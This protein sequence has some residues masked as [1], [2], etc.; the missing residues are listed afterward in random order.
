MK[1]LITQNRRI[2]MYIGCF[3]VFALM[4][5]SYGQVTFKHNFEIAVEFENYPNSSAWGDIDNDGD[6]DAYMSVGS[7]VG[8]DIMFNDLANSG[9][10]VKADTLLGHVVDTAGPRSVLVVDID[11]DGD[12][13]LL[14]VGQDYQIWLKLNQ[15]IEA[16]SLYFVDVSEETGVAHIEEAYYCATMAD[17]DN[18]G[19]L[20][21]V[22]T[23]LC[24]NGWFPTL[25]FR[26][27]TPEGG[28]ISFE[29][30]ADIA[31]IL[32]TNGMNS[33][34]ASWA[35]YDDDGDQDVLIGTMGNWPEFLYRNEGD[36]TFTDVTLDIGMENAIG[37]T[38][39][40]VWGDYDNDGDLDVFI[41]R[42]PNPD[43]AG[44]DVC[45]FYR[46]DGGVFSDVVAAQITGYMT[47]GVA[48]GDYDNDGDLDLHILD[49][50][51]PDLMLR[52][53]GNFN[54]T[55]VT[56]E[57]KLLKAASSS[58]WGELD[59]NDRG[60]QTWADWDADGD[61]DLLL[62]SD[63]GIKPYLMRNDGGNANNWLEVRLEGTNSN[64]SAI[65]AR[66][67]A[68]ASDLSQIREVVMGSGYLC[69][70]ATDMHF[71]L[72]Q[73]TTVDSLIVKWPSGLI[74]V[75]TDID[76]NQLVN[77]R[78][79]VL[80]DVEQRISDR[81]TDFSLLQNYPN[82]FNPNTHISYKLAKPAHVRME[83]YS[84]LGQHLLTLVNGYETA[85]DYTVDFD[86]SN[87]AAGVYIY[88]ITA[89]NMTQQKKMILLK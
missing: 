54:F 57:A 58:G 81:P 26:N 86:A 48:A 7:S 73:L 76:A 64:R 78:E 3:M 74:E 79:G 2:R 16:D 5:T 15:L 34:C 32:S 46:N 30:T 25:L 9:I 19:K 6:L 20:D 33:C 14:A 62:P 72:G 83:V 71:G 63:S 65:G 61:L 28:P 18:D 37:E 52:N 17:Y 51:G 70:P 88:R 36:G 55:D 27:T 68:V 38:R 40:V 35:D 42:R 69:G 10:F 47:Y 13:D 12:Q 60:G 80:S 49:L 29:E 31:G 84:T 44:M 41:G 67:T 8:F 39:S 66:V 4:S 23:G 22:I 53:D 11:N 87:L 82:P 21:I 77:I 24:A 43:Y 56:A 50:E 59:I 89:N 1:A 75:M 85:G 45:Q